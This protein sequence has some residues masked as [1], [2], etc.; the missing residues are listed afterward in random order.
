MKSL[1]VDA[2]E[3]LEAPDTEFDRFGLDSN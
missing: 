1:L 3:A 2:M